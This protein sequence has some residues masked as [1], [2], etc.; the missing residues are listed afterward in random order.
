LLRVDKFRPGFS[1]RILDTG[2][3]EAVPARMPPPPGCFRKRGCKLMKTK[4]GR[5]GKK[6]KRLQEYG[7]KRVGA[8]YRRELSEV[9]Q[10]RV[11]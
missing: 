6:G 1:G 11:P 5:G 7:N 2:D 8:N 10:E 4:E 3:V 9:I